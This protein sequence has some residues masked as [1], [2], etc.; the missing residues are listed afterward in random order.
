MTHES[1]DDQLQ[2]HKVKK[3]VS[4]QFILLITVEWSA[5]KYLQ[6]VTVRLFHHL[7]SRCVS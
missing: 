5:D 1:I 3:M 2:E 7:K 6:Q 4:I